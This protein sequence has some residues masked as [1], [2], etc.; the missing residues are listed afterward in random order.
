MMPQS[1]IVLLL[2]PLDLRGVAKRPDRNIIRPE[3]CRVNIIRC[4]ST[5][6]WSD[7]TL[8]FLLRLSQLI[9]PIT[10]QYPLL[11]APSSRHY[12]LR[13]GHD[14]LSHSASLPL[15]SAN[16]WPVPLNT[17]GSV[18][19]LISPPASPRSPVL[20]RSPHSSVWIGGCWRLTSS[21]CGS[22]EN[23]GPH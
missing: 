12:M 10:A 19:P 3:S 13:E 9:A 20:L 6:A 7:W 1:L 2:P 11:D 5:W 21:R 17:P 16:R 22:A 14:L 8:W 18:S 4:C 23:T 15:S